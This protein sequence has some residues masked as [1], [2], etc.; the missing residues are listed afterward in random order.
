MQEC[1]LA[2]FAGRQTP[3]PPVAI[4]IDDGDGG[5][6]AWAARRAGLREQVLYPSCPQTWGTKAIGTRPE[7][8]RGV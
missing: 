2:G 1:D 6:L 3:C 5:G 7:N 4:L 8:N